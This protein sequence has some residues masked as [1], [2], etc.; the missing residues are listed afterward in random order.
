MKATFSF[1]CLLQSRDTKNTR[2][3]FSVKITKNLDILCTDKN[4]RNPVTMALK[5]KKS[6]SRVYVEG[7]M[8]NGKG[9]TGRTSSKVEENEICKGI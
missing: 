5:L 2:G 1:V 4:S 9:K 3:N 8:A 6:L 7:E